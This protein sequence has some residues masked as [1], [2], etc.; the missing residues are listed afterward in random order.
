MGTPSVC[1][2]EGCCCLVRAKVWEFV[3]S[4]VGGLRG[5]ERRSNVGKWLLW[6]DLDG[7]FCSKGEAAEEDEDVLETLSS[8][9]ESPPKMRRVLP[10][11]TALPPQSS[12]RNSTVLA[13]T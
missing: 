9:P 1:C 2:D 5:R 3:E 10:S 6:A 12:R 11:P 8:Y 4:D 7:H 13:H